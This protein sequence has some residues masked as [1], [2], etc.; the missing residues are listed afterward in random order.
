MKKT[1]L[2]FLCLLCSFSAWTQSEKITVSDLARIK[3]ISGISLS[4]DGKRAIYSLNY[5]EPSEENKAEYDYK[6]QLWISD[7]QSVKMFIRAEGNPRQAVWSPDGNS[8]AFV[9]TVKGKGQIFVLPLNGGEAMQLTDLS[10]G[11][12]APRWMP[13]GQR[14]VFSIS[15][16]LNEMLKDSLF[17]PTKSVPVWSL[18]KP[19]FSQNSFLKNDAKTKANPDGT[20]EEVRAYL[21]KNE[22]DKKAKV[23]NRLQFQGE[24]STET[25][26][27]FS[28]LMQVELRENAK[29][30]ALTSGF[31]SYSLQEVTPSGGLLLTMARDTLA[32]P[33]REQ[34]SVIVLLENNKIIRLVDQKD[35]S[36]SSV[37]RSPTGQWM[38]FIG[39]QTGQVSGSRLWIA[40][41]DGSA[42]QE[43]NFARS[44]GN[45]TWSVDGQFLYF[46]AS[47]NG[48][49]PVYRWESNSKK[50][51]QLS[52]YEKGI[53]DFDLSA[54]RLIYAQ[55]EVSNPSELY[56]ADTQMKN[57]VRLSNHNDW[58]A[59]KQLSRPE[60]FTFQNDKDQTIEY[61]VMKPTATESGK[62][63]PLLLQMHGGP[64]AMWGPGESSMWHELQFFCAKGYG[65]VYANPRG[66]GGYGP[67]FQA[68]NYRDWGSGPAS[69]VLGACTRAAQAGW[70]DTSRQVITGGSYAGYLTAWIVAHDH[71]FKAA[72][73]QRGVYDL[74]TFM[75]EGNAWRLVPNY[76]GWPWD[77]A[78]KPILERESPYTYLQNIRTPLLIKHGENDLRTGVIQSEM[79]YKSMKI[80]GKE[81][82]YVRVPGATHE[83]SR[84]GNVRQR[85]DRILRI[86]E[87]FERFIKR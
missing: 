33:D 27:R 42:R 44:A 56:W 31:W 17:N 38:A 15:I 35:W 53:N 75:G 36:F 67:D 14:L 23:F 26:L 39:N 60:K 10:Y 62:K 41:A 3:Q 86:Y 9:R 40:K 77:A 4:P 24:A 19:G 79:L 52:D 66:S 25:E 18:E 29:P 47:S 8:I 7:F 45:L 46:T 50:I 63:Y 34:N 84:S 65:V 1:H 69:D 68:S 71:R 83:L 6:S 51:V 58:V 76:F 70:V 22:E 28:H 43:L 37:K 20:L 11:A 81:V 32:H 80:L 55:T 87:F 30:K 74:R 57:P 59:Q 64:T 21:R 54:G 61:W 13:D 85:M 48:G 72:F 5:M 73:A 12:S 82:E 2:I 49:V 16:S 78:A